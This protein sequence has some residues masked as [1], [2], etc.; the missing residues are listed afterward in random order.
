[1]Q[2][3]KGDTM[4]ILLDKERLDPISTTIDRNFN[5]EKNWS[6][7]ERKLYFSLPNESREKYRNC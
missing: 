7:L 2:G 6:T 1:M 3:R 5:A 4:E